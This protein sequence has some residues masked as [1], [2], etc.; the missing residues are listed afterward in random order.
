MEQQKRIAI[1]AEKQT[2][3]NRD[4]MKEWLTRE[5]P[6]SDQV[7][8]LPCPPVQKP[9]PE[10]AEIYDLPEPKKETLIHND[11]FKAIQNRQSKRK[12]DTQPLTLDEFSYL[13]WSTQG[14]KK[15]VA[16]GKATMR[17]VPSAGARH[18]F[19]TYIAV[20]WVEDLKP[21]MYRYL[22]VEHKLEFLFE[23]DDMTKKLIEAGVGQ[24]FVGEC[25]ACFIWS[26]IPYRGEWR[27]SL[28]SHK[29]MLLD[30]GHICQNLY[31]A[32]ETIEC[33]TCAIGAYNQDI[34][35][36][37]LKLDG[38]DEFVVYLSPVGKV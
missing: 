35:D 28:T 26:C 2:L 22:A 29:N 16:N 21:G 34:I 37:Y 4:F 13:L 9:I 23:D 32:C 31:I 10:G 38:K 6:V 7:K 5:H 8:G 20:N 33:G 27:Y 24:R 25:A 1:A 18:P 19:E 3:V 30:A 11:L 17:T 14:I 36:N 12:F 15:I